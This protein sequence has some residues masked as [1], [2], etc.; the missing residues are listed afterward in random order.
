MIRMELR[1]IVARVVHSVI[2]EPI[3]QVLQEQAVWFAE[4]EFHGLVI[5]LRHLNGTAG[6]DIH[7]VLGR[8]QPLVVKDL[9]PKQNVIGGKG[10]TV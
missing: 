4:F 9:V 3:S 1:Q 5:D 8:C 6:T 2:A 10:C 7:R